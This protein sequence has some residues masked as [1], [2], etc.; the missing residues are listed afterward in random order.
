MAENRRYP[1]AAMI[2]FTR[3][4]GGGWNGTYTFEPGPHQ[5]KF[6]VD[7]NTWIDDPTNPMTV[8]D[9][10]GNINSLYTCTP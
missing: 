10:M 4:A 7:T 3:D 2:A 5:Y 8:D 1:V 6:I 9:G